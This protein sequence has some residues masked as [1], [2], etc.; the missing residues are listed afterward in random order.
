MRLACALFFSP[1]PSCI[2]RPSFAFFRHFANFTHRTQI[3]SLPKVWIHLRSL[4]IRLI[5]MLWNK[6]RSTPSSICLHGSVSILL[7]TVSTSL[8]NCRQFLLDHTLSPKPEI[9]I[10][11]HCLFTYGQHF[12]FSKSTETNPS[13]VVQ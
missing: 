10:F 8:P 3:I 1:F 2:F 4:K 5:C 6:S 9:P 7:Y 11:H 12:L 13:K